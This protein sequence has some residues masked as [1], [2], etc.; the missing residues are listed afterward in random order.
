MR[1]RNVT[2]Q[3]G[4][5]DLNW[6][7]TT[8]SALAALSSAVLLSTLGA[9]GT[10]VG[11]AVGS[12]VVTVGGAVYSH[13]LSVSRA[14]VSAARSAALVRAA[15][16]RARS[17]PAS[18]DD[19]LA[20]VTRAI[21][22]SPERFPLLSASAT[23][24]T[25][26]TPRTTA[27]ATAPAGAP[28]RR[29]IDG[30]LPGESTS[31]RQ[32]LRGTRWKPALAASLGVFVLVMGLIVSME[33]ATGRA[34]SSYTGGS[35]ADGPRTSFA[36]LGST[37]DADGGD[38]GTNDPAEGGKHSVSGD[39]AT[40]GARAQDTGGDGGSSSRT[41][42]EPDTGAPR[43]DTSTSDPDAGTT[44]QP[45]PAPT[46]DTPSEP[47]PE[48]TPAPTTQAPPEAPAPTTGAAVGGAAADSVS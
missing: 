38:S 21:S 48:P 31:W 42:S 18:T 22:A 7:Q 43:P 33:L 24:G 9:A 1:G 41:G 37:S 46:P 32:L 13:Y 5:L 14:R 40:G 47:A 35:S 23:A 16:V 3:A 12:I 19:S 26:G 8:G 36:L 15:R 39:T 25:T 34:L 20:A 17:G 2:N 45:T 27:P 11:A 29:L 6:V 30:N 28:G 4:K 10:L 44:P